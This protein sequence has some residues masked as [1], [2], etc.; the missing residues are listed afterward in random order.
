MIVRRGP[1]DGQPEVLDGAD[2]LEEALQADR[3]RDEAVGV[4]LVG[5]EDVVVVLGRGQDYHGDPP[6]VFVRL[7]RNGLINHPFLAST[8]IAPPCYVFIKL[9]I[10]DPTHISAPYITHTAFLR[11]GSI[12]LCFPK[13][14]DDDGLYTQY[15]GNPISINPRAKK[16]VAHELGHFI[17]A[18]LDQSF[19]YNDCARPSDPTL[20]SIVLHLW[21]SYIDGSPSQLAPYDLQYRQRLA[22]RLPQSLIEK[23]WNGAFTTYADLLQA[24][25]GASGQEL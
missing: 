13:I 24:A 17:D 21:D 15:P 19:A 1:D 22:C 4:Q 20:G 10:V 5:H 12:S 6:Q 23:A 11:D 3:V 18:R 14:G 7:D 16:L 25:T 2:D 8:G 9:N